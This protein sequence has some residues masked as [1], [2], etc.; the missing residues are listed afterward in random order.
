MISELRFQYP[1]EEFAEH[2]KAMPTVREWEFTS[3]FGFVG[4]AQT[5]RANNARVL[6]YFSDCYTD[7]N[8]ALYKAELFLIIYDYI[9]RNAALFSKKGLLEQTEGAT[10]VA[11]PAL[12]RA[13]HYALIR[14]GPDAGVA[15]KKVLT[16]AKALEVF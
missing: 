1:Y 9:A 5:S 15:A 12:L 3:R 2:M 16:L 8:E 4:D 14:S 10:F 13:V 6:E 11:E 7:P